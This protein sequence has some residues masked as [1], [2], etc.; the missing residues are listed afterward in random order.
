MLDTTPLSLLD[1]DNIPVHTFRPS[2][3]EILWL[4]RGQLTMKV[5]NSARKTTHHVMVPDSTD[6]A[7]SE[8]EPV[9]TPA[10]T[11]AAGAVMRH[12]VMTRG[13]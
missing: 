13:T 5:T 12:R 2:Y 6:Q 4:W 11:P 9:V 3:R 8:G 10:N 1:T 7:P